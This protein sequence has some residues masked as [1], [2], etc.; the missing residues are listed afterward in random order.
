MSTL[1]LTVLEFIDAHRP[2]RE[3]LRDRFGKLLDLADRELREVGGQWH[4]LAERKHWSS[5][6]YLRDGWREHQERD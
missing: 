3:E 2:T 5:R 1:T 4:R 6:Y